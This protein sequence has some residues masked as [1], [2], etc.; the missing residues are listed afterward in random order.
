[1]YVEGFFPNAT[2][3]GIDID[4]R[5]KTFEQD[6][7]KIY[8]GSQH[9]T[10]FLEGV[11]KDI[12][13]IDIVIDDGSHH[14]DHQ[15]ISFETLFPYVKSKGYY[16]IEDLHFAYH[17]GSLQESQ[18]GQFFPHI[19]NTL[20]K[21]VDDIHKVRVQKIQ[22][23]AMVLQRAVADDQRKFESM[24]FYNGICLIRKM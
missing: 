9:D 4:E 16:V 11:V 14:E 8:I 18:Y 19:T 20:I 17:N 22:K 1:M 15:R 21:V 10:N 3:H 12:G 24:C 13:K 5:C 23:G 2:I 7:I 6:R